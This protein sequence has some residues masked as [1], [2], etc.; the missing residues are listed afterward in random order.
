MGPIFLA[1]INTADSP[2]YK[3]EEMSNDITEM[4]ECEEAIG[5]TDAAMVRKDLQIES[6]ETRK[7][8]TNSKDG[9]RTLEMKVV[10]IDPVDAAIYDQISGQSLKMA[11]A[12]FVN[13][14]T[15]FTMK[16]E[17]PGGTRS[18]DVVKIDTD[19]SCLFGALAHQLFGC[20]LASEAHKQAVQ[21]LR[22]DIVDFIRSNLDVFEN[23]IKECIIYEN[24][25]G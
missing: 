17:V 2:V 10:A 24:A 25:K 22:K 20:E 5:A 21:K 14:E 1:T 15:T 12:C 19:G 16:F 18:L 6:I 8:S 11:E 4:E 7:N 3:T 13:G 23:E 9:N